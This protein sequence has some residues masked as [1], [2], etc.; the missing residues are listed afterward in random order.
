MPSIKE[1]SDPAQRVRT[2]K[3]RREQRRAASHT[4]VSAAFQE[5]L[6]SEDYFTFY[7]DTAFARSPSASPRS[8]YRSS[9]AAI[10][11]R[12]SSAEQAGMPP[13]PPLEASDSSDSID[14]L[15]SVESADD[16]EQDLTRRGS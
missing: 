6:G 10:R 14:S 5:A 1:E 3:E 2:F 13:V 16:G 7:H 11:S 9:R 8:T 15:D 12:K 4:S